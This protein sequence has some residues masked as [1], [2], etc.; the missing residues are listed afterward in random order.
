[1]RFNDVVSFIAAAVQ[2]NATLP[3]SAS[4]ADRT[5]I[6]VLGD[7]GS[8]KSQLGK[9]VQE[10]VKANTGECER[11]A[12]LN[13]AV[14]EPNDVAGWAVEAG[15]GK[16]MKVLRPHWMNWEDGDK[17]PW[18]VEVDELKQGSTMCQNAAARIVYERAINGWALPVNSTVIAFANKDSNKAGTTKMPTHLRDRFV[19][20][21]LDPSVDDAVNYFYSVGAHPDVPAFLQ[22]NRSAYSKFDPHA[23]SPTGRGWHG[24]SSILKMG[25]PEHVEREAIAGRVGV[26]MA[27][28]FTAFRKL[29][30]NMPDPKA[31]VAS[32]DSAPIPAEPAVLYALTSSLV[33]LATPE[34]AGK[35]IAYLSRLPQQEFA[36]MWVKAAC[37]KNAEI[38]RSA[39]VRKWAETTGNQLVGTMS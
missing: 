22:F 5:N 23:V 20:L 3:A 25:L 13:L 21:E 2:Y 19:V 17:R 31:C 35:V 14:L 26:G 10:M 7:P 30:E 8:G 12:S 33:E 32:P 18:I 39:D 24:I 29:K 6:L 9:A 16:N 28:E 1:M 27:A 34:N 36:L 11:N 38:K 15:D 4:D 37:G